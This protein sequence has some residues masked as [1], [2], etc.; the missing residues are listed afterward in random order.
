MLRLF[1]FFILG[2]LAVFSNTN[3]QD[4]LSVKYDTQ[5][6]RLRQIQKEDLAVYEN[7][8]DFNYE[9][10][11]QNGIQW[12][13][14]FKTWIGN[15]LLRIFEIFFG[16]GKAVGYL[17]IFLRIIPYILLLFLLFLLIK[18]FLNVNSRTIVHSKKN[19]AIVSLS[20]EEHIIKNEDISQLIERALAANDYR[21]AVRYYYLYMLQIMTEKDIIAWELQKTNEDY[22]KEI[23]K[24]HLKQPFTAITRLY[25]YIWYGGFDIDA[26]KYARAEV[27]FSSLQNMLE[28]G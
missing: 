17:A 16:V 7:N 26:T 5:P 14:D 28:N 21:L 9:V 6:L 24:S 15:I 27:Q 19:S 2:S 22:L 8:P 23:K 25:D 4:S 12:W 1:V 20:E 13:E 11:Q 10:V 3:Q 18:F